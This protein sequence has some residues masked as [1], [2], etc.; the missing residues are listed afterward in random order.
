MNIRDLKTL[1]LVEIKCFHDFK[2]QF[3]EISAHLSVVSVISGFVF[4]FGL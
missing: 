1:K 4:M 3:S 2:S